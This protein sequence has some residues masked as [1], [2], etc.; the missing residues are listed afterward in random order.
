MIFK[1][2]HKMLLSS[3][4]AHLCH[5][6]FCMIFSCLCVLFIYYLAYLAYLTLLCEFCVSVPGFV[7][8]WPSA[9][10]YL[11]LLS[12]NNESF[13]VTVSVSCAICSSSVASHLALLTLL[14]TPGLVLTLSIDY[15]ISR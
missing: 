11:L 6:R 5:L 15:L 4:T 10:A 1:L 14:C 13:S 8:S 7:F 9:G 2:L 12:K 3:I